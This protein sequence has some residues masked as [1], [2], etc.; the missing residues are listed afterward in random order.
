M[1]FAFSIALLAGLAVAPARAGIVE[2]NA[3]LCS[4]T[5][6]DRDRIIG[7]CT[8]LLVSGMLDENL[9]AVYNNRALA[10]ANKGEND[11][12]ISD[13]D[14]AIALNPDLAITYYNRGLAYRNKGQHGLSIRDYDKAISLNPD[15]GYAHGNRG[16]AYESLGNKAAALRDFRKQYDLGSRPTW[17]IDKLREYGALP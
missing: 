2:T 12:A 6:V 15:Y 3:A 17:L 14:K 5:G 1:R 4:D 8:W 11:K 16:V 13:Y 10:Y 7:A 9:Y